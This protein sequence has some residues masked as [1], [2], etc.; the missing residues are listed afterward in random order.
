MLLRFDFRM[1]ERGL[2][3]IEVII[4]LVL[5]GAMA[6]FGF[7]RLADAWVRQSVRSA[8]AALVGLYAKGRATAIER[9]AVTRVIVDNNRVRIESVDPVTG[10]T[11]VVGSVE[12]LGNRYGVR[13]LPSLDTCVYDPRGVAREAGET[14]V[15]I[16][17]G[18]VVQVLRINQLGRVIR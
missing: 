9:G 11:V 16:S 18:S 14:V 4:V 5:I 7:P 2:T 17:R 3:L 10:A 15:T 13:I 12:D 8:R 6:G 1:R